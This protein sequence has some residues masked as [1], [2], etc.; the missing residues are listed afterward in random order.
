MPLAKELLSCNEQET[1]GMGFFLGGL[2]FQHT[3]VCVLPERACV[4][5]SNTMLSTSVFDV[6]VLDGVHRHS[7]KRFWICIPMMKLVHVGV[8]RTDVQEPVRNVKV[9]VTPDD[10]H[11]VITS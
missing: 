7:R 11:D 2:P 9:N 1:L 5:C 10:R 8:D 6:Q 3:C 4:Y